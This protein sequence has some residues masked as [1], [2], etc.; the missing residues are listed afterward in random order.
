MKS[1]SAKKTSAAASRQNGVPP[2]A[3]LRLI[4]DRRTVRRFQDKPAPAG[5]LKRILEAGNWAPFSAYAPQGRMF[6]ALMGEEREAAAE[7]VKRCPAILKYLRIQYEASPYGHEQEWTDKA[8]VFGGTM[9]NAPVLIVTVVKVMRERFPMMHN[10]AAAWAATQN[11]MIQATAEGLAS[12]V[13][14]FS[15]PKIQAELLQRLGLIPGEWVVANVLN[16]GYADE[17][18]QPPSRSTDLMTIRG[19]IK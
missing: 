17:Q 1:K 5:A 11:M 12:G 10:M 6:Y 7:I 13:V 3:V 18:P 15:T 4:K 8:R 9:G 2:Q 19:S 14:T 16:V